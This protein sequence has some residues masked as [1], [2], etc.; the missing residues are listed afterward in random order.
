MCI[1]DRPVVSRLKKMDSLP[2]VSCTI[3]HAS[4][5]SS[6]G[7]N[8]AIFYIVS[9]IYGEI[10]TCIMLPGANSVK[11]DWVRSSL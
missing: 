9:D 6:Q 10:K 8:Y 1:R 7:F 3:N 5:G 2:W 4:G 11:R